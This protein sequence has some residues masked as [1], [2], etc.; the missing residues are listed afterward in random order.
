MKQYILYLSFADE[1]LNTNISINEQT[2]TFLIHQ[3]HICSTILTAQMELNY[4]VEFY[5]QLLPFGN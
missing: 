5:W 3:K 2:I 1:E 4:N